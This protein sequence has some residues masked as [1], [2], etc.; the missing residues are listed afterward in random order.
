MATLLKIFSASGAAATLT[1]TVKSMIAVSPFAKLDESGTNKSVNKPLPVY[2]LFTVKPGVPIT[3][4]VPTITAPLAVNTA[5]KLSFTLNL[6]IA[7]AP[8]FTTLIL[9]GTVQYVVESFFKPVVTTSF[10]KPNLVFGKSKR[11]TSL[12]F[13]VKFS[14]PVVLPAIVALLTNGPLF[15]FKV[16]LI[17]YL[18][19]S[20]AFGNIKPPVFTMLESVLLNKSFGVK[21]VFASTV[22][23]VLISH[24]AGVL[25]V[26]A[27]SL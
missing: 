11:N 10:A 25:N 5:S 14:L 27:K 2:F 12:T 24:V 15:P 22:G 6:A 1:L 16:T 4:G 21:F 20:I 17:T 8:I 9:Y 19:V 26:L 7:F 18:M 3:V 23:F 13:A